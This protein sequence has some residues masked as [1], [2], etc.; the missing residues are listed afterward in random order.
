MTTQEN[1][2]PPALNKI[3]SVLISLIVAGLLLGGIWFAS[4][5][6]SNRNSASPTPASGTSVTEAWPT[7]PPTFTP[8]P[9]PT[10]PG[11][12]TPT[13]LPLPA[14]QEIG[15]FATIEYFDS[16]DSEVIRNNWAPGKDRADVRVVASIKMGI[17]LNETQTSDLQPENR[18][19]KVV[20][21]PI[22]ILSISYLKDRSQILDTQQQWVLSNYP[23][24]EKEAM[25][26]GLAEIEQRA[27]NNERMLSIATELTR[28]RVE[29]LLRGYGF[30]TV[31]VSFR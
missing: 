23:G 27:R 1:G 21:P 30:T 12:A 29:R 13:P 14:W 15:E 10:V 4:R 18:A 9:A 24:I 6:F 28:S 25:D 26:K 5:Q 22:K 7:P 3:A 16:V 11:V 31:D 2:S 20:L 8:I 17:D 19:I